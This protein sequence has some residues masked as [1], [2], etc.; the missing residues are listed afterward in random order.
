[1]KYLQFEINSY[2]GIEGPIEINVDKSRLVPIIGINESGKSTILKAIF[3]FDKYNDAAS[4]S[5][6]HLEEVK[7]LYSAAPRHPLIVAKISATKHD[8]KSALHAIKT[9][10]RLG[11]D[12]KRAEYLPV[13]ET[14]INLVKRNFKGEL[15]LYRNLNTKKYGVYKF[16]DKAK[17]ELLIDL[18]VREL[19]N[20]LPYILYF[21][22]FRDSIV[23]KI[24]IVKDKDG[25]MEYWLQVVEQ[26]F[27]SA[28][29]KYGENFSVFDLPEMDDRSRKNILSKVNKR[30]REALRSCQLSWCKFG[31]H[32]CGLNQTNAASFA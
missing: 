21:D 27:E 28:A 1:M 23:D 5:V 25:K 15:L 3:S 6:K 20:Y 14:Y 9:S 26:L 30:L 17:N 11:S 19:I 22:D 18:F 31:K 10:A 32:G 16:F 12:P 8:L 24:E 4:V 7:N 29:D 2:R 13:I